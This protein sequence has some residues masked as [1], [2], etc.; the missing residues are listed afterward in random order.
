MQDGEAKQ[1]GSLAE[2]EQT[3]RHAD[4]IKDLCTELASTWFL[5]DAFCLVNM[6]QNCVKTY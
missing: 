1:T 6:R 3:G 4:E 2:D 5:S